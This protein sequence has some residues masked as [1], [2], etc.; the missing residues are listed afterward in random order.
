MKVTTTGKVS[1]LASAQTAIIGSLWLSQS[2]YG[3][4]QQNTPKSPNIIFM[5]ADDH[6]V[7]AI[8]AFGSKINKTPNIDRIAENGAKFTRNFCANSICSPS[9]ACVITGKHSHMNGVTEWQKFDGSQF[10]FPK[11]LQAA[12]YSTGIFGKWHL[13]SNPTGFDEW[14]VYP[15][16]GHYYNPVYRTP[17]GNKKITGYSVDVTTD[18]AL[19]FL[20]RSKDSGKPFLL[21]CQ[22][23]APHR[24]WMPATRFLHKYDDVTIPE[25]DTLF[26]DYSDRASPAAKHRMGIDKHMRMSYDL[27]VPNAKGKGIYDHGRMTP[28]QRAAWDA[29]YGPKNKAFKDANLKGK[30]LVKWKYQRYIKDYL[31]CIAAVDENVGRILD[32]LKENGLDK[33]TIVVYSADQGFYLG[34]HGWFDKRWMYEES[35][36]MPLIISWPGVIKPGTTIS[37]LTQ[38]IDFAPTFLEAAGLPVPAEIQGVS[39]IPLFKDPKAPWRDALYYHYYN[40]GGNKIQPRGEHGVPR[41]C[42]VRTERYKL[43][44]YYT[45]GEWE[46]FDLKNDPEEL[47]SEYDNP[48]YAAIRKELKSKLDKLVKQYDAPIVEVGKAPDL[49]RYKTSGKAK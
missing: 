30:E 9:R 4:P 1:I 13:G 19:G 33:N 49:S 25:P 5:F 11:A 27:K 20:Q 24:T 48:E 40:H 22:F 26:D 10:T 21:M 23:K 36:R 37:Q 3:A 12:G 29:A 46:L 2:V 42:G 16:Q 38:N 34:E 31:R 35:F 32:F 18:Q 45:T 43:I 15:G 6:A 28:E 41:H 17:Q 14:M 44:Q 47:H 7:Q 8:S 39:L